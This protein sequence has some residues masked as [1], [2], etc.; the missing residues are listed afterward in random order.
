MFPNNQLLPLVNFSINVTSGYAPLSV[1]FL[2]DSILMANSYSPP[3]HQVVTEADNGRSISLENG[4]TFY[5]RLKECADGAYFWGLS[6]T[7]GL[8]ILSES[9]IDDNPHPEGPVPD[10]IMP[11]IGGGMAVHVWEIKAVAQGIQQVKSRPLRNRIGPEDNFTLNITN[12][13]QNITSGNWD[14]GDG[15]NSTEQ[16]PTHTYFSAGNYTI[17]L[18]VT[19][20]NGTDSKNATITVFEKPILPIA[21]FSSDGE[22]SSGGSSH[23]S[24]SSGGG[25]AGGSP[26]P[27]NNVEAKELSQTYIACGQ[28][29]KFDFPQ[30]T[31]PVVSVIFDSK[32][33]VGKTI[34]IAEMLKGRSTL[35]SGEPSDEVYK[36]FNV[37]VGNSGFATSKNIKNAVV[38]FKVVKS[39]IHDKNIDQSSI[40]LN[41]YS[42]KKWDQLP[43]NLSGEDN[44]YLY[45]T[46]Q[47]PGFS[48]FAITGKMKASRTEIQPAAGTKTQPTSVNEKQSNAS[49]GKSSGLKTGAESTNNSRKESTKTPGF[50]IV[51]GI[52]SLLCVFL[53]KRR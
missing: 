26:E 23:S 1:Q 11:W 51:S 15:A 3:R 50:E 2:D 14:F 9:Y 30:K 45:F 13:P 6:F 32:K 7:P 38:D 29:V 8:C 36:F 52:V 4:E 53:Y 18:R 20:A 31:I 25:G 21:D 49:S 44:Q 24:S 46:A 35:V 41:M 34:T 16:N 12:L 42:D 39:W 19:N 22:S 17:N 40:S 37:W 5:I 33:T 48:S 47:T 10:G 28:F 43:T 27:Q